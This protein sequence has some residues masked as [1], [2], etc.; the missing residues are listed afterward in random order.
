M[1]VL[2]WFTDISSE[3]PHNSCRLEEMDSKLGIPWNEAIELESVVQF[4]DLSKDLKAVLRINIKFPA[5]NYIPSY[6]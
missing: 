1:S 6:K 2:L 4:I 5:L 3:S